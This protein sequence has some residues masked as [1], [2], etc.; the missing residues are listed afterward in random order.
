MTD[1]MC[2]LVLAAVVVV[3]NVLTYHGSLQA[4]QGTAHAIT[5]VLPSCIA[6]RA[7]YCTCHNSS[8]T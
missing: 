7:R 8:I 4:E 6:G 2:H 1:A 5:A 3:A